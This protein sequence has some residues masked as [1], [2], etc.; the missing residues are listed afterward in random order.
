M[1]I[2][3]L[4]IIY[5]LSIIYLGIHPIIYLLFTYSH[6]YLSIY[7]CLSVLTL[8]R[9]PTNAVFSEESQL[10]SLEVPPG[11]RSVSDG[12]HEMVTNS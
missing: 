1:L 10:I 6:I 4:Y 7:L 11:F 12:I 3:I 8:L 5:F 2:N 9:I